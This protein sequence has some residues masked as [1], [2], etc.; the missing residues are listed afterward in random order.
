MTKDELKT[1]FI[2]RNLDKGVIHCDEES[3]N[4][5]LEMLEQQNMRVANIVLNYSFLNSGFKNI[6]KFYGFVQG[7]HLSEDNLFFDLDIPSCN[8]GTSEEFVDKL[9]TYIEEVR[10]LV[11]NLKKDITSTKDAIAIY[12]NTTEVSAGDLAKAADSISLFDDYARLKPENQNSGG[13]HPAQQSAPKSGS[14]AISYSSSP[15][16]SEATATPT[17]V[18]SKP[19][20]NLYTPPQTENQSNQNTQ[21]IIKDNQSENRNQN[22]GN[23]ANKNETQTKVP[24][25]KPI[26]S[27]TTKTDIADATKVISNQ[28]SSN[29][30]K[31][32]S[33]SL[34]GSIIG[35]ITPKGGEKVTE[36]LDNE[37]TKASE[38]I[39]GKGTLTSS[40]G[41]IKDPQETIK[42]E[43]LVNPNIDTSEVKTSSAIPLA[44]GALAAGTAGVGTKVYLNKQEEKD[45]EEKNNKET[46]EEIERLDEK[47]QEFE[48]LSVEEKIKAM[49]N[50]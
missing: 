8:N 25:N 36:I 39:A 46:T 47:E 26:N 6:D 30:K 43:K 48:P 5:G 3:V 19:V 27:N 35:A 10:D 33:S 49:M 31:T 14:R 20:E 28:L 22:T 15:I 42:I 41:M 11:E 45:D 50:N 12:S 7:G 40:V 17:T 18:E 32:N 13:E 23:I 44:A 37:I 9:H 4:S 34:S 2:H 1:G 38:V 29:D 16:K 21:N 24:D